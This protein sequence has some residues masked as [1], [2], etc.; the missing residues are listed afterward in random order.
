[1]LHKSR[2]AKLQCSVG[3]YHAE[4]MCMQVDAHDPDRD[5]PRTFKVAT[6]WT[7]TVDVQEL[8]D[9]VQ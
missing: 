9:F 5:R 1:M 8:L 7:A 6:K 4:S 2:S 3:A